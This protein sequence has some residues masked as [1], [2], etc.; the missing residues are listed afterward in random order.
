MRAAAIGARVDRHALHATQLL[1]R[2]LD[3]V[4]GHGEMH[5]DLVG[6]HVAAGQDLGDQVEIIGMGRDRD[7]DRGY[8]Q[9]RA[10]ARQPA[11]NRC[12][13]A[14]TKIGPIVSAASF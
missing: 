3:L 2:C 10:A 4:G 6:Q 7:P 12:T 13:G 14:E 11:R 5:R 8:R 1:G 9:R